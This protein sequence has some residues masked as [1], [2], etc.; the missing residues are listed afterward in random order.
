MTLQNELSDDMALGKT[1]AH[2]R[3]D[4]TADNTIVAEEALRAPFSGISDEISEDFSISDAALTPSTTIADHINETAPLS[5]TAMEL[6]EGGMSFQ[7]LVALVK[8]LGEQLATQ[9]EDNKKLKADYAALQRQMNRKCEDDRI[10]L[11]AQGGRVA[12]L[13][14]LVEA[15]FDDAKK[16]ICE[17]NRSLKTTIGSATEQVDKTYEHLCAAHGYSDEENTSQDIARTDAPVSDEDAEFWARDAEITKLLADLKSS[18]NAPRQKRSTAVEDVASLEATVKDLGVELRMD[19]LKIK[20]QLKSMNQRQD[21]AFNGFKAEINRLRESAL[22]EE[23][24]VALDAGMIVGKPYFEGLDNDI[25]WLR[26][27]LSAAEDRLE[28]TMDE[29]VQEINGKVFGRLDEDGASFSKR[30]DE[31]EE[32]RAVSTAT[33]ESVSAKL[34]NI[35]AEFLKV[36]AAFAEAGRQARQ[37]SR[38]IASLK[39]RQTKDDSLALPAITDIK[40]GLDGAREDTKTTAIADLEEMVVQLSTDAKTTHRD[41]E[42]QNALVWSIDNKFLCSGDKLEK[43]MEDAERRIKNLEPKSGSEGSRF[44]EDVRDIEECVK[45]AIGKLKSLELKSGPG[46]SG[47]DRDSKSPSPFTPLKPT[48]GSLIDAKDVNKLSMALKKPSPKS[49]DTSSSKAPSPSAAAPSL[50]AQAKEFKPVTGMDEQEYEDKYDQLHEDYDGKG[51]RYWADGKR[52]YGFWEDMDT[53]PDWGE[54]KE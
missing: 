25:Q 49:H 31:L 16:E 52:M 10:V 36:N 17:L 18:L 15:K 47:I 35:D 23:Y 24:F 19:V 46:I 37:V 8:N 44:G 43:K 14:K 20:E 41:V 9:S 27:A 45:D 39:L 13:E 53:E 26:D 38:E 12:N 32:E 33:Q 48:P 30:L 51:P 54:I 1:Q 21:A 22:T 7:D 42:E 5:G 34:E 50:R 40:E 6:P 11:T 3:F 28:R 29:K 4:G 2:F